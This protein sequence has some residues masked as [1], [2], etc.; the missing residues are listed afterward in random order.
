MGVRGDSVVTHAVGAF[1][2][3]LLPVADAHT[4]VRAAD[5]DILDYLPS[6]DRLA[7]A[8]HYSVRC[9]ATRALTP[10]VPVTDIPEYFKTLCDSLPR[11]VDSGILVNNIHGVLEQMLQL[12]SNFTNLSGK[13]SHTDERQGW[14]VMLGSVG[15]WVWLAGPSSPNCVLRA[16]AFRVFRV[17]LKGVASTSSS[18][19]IKELAAMRQPLLDAAVSALKEEA[20]QWEVAGIVRRSAY[21][22]VFYA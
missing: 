19:E 20:K 14:R 3:H 12:V 22:P 4:M 7:K 11:A 15:Q 9:M 6:V 10:I 8:A 16:L 21:A 17:I 1:L 5:V 18:S 2:S 13:S